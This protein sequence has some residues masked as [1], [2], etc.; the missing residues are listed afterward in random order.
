MKKVAIYFTNNNGEYYIENICTLTGY[1][2]QPSS[3]PTKVIDETVDW[4]N[5]EL[6]QKELYNPTTGDGDM[7]VVIKELEE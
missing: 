3:T 5:Y 6:T 7:F 2:I 1:T 4:R